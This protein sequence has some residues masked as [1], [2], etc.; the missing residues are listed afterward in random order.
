[1]SA[2]DTHIG[3]RVRVTTS[4][5]AGVPSVIE[6]DLFAID[7]ARGL[8]VL[9][10]V[11]T[12]TYQKADYFFVPVAALTEIQVL[13]DADRPAIISVQPAESEKRLRDA[14]AAENVKLSRKG[15]GVSERSQRIFDELLKQ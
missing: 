2:N 3:K 15:V 11:H 7:G 4:G 10:R 5:V 6:A 13:G 14:I 8:A 12:H 1:M 9:R